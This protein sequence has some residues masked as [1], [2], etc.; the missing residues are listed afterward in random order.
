MT[1]Q[2]FDRRAGIVD[3]LGKDYYQSIT[4]SNDL[5][6]MHSQINTSRQ[7]FARFRLRNE[8]ILQQTQPPRYIGSIPLNSKFIPPKLRINIEWQSGIKVEQIVVDP[9]LSGDELMKLSVQTLL[10]ADIRVTLDRPIIIKVRGIRSYICGSEPIFNYDYI[11]KCLIDGRTPHLVLMHTPQV[12]LRS[13]SGGSPCLVDRV[14]AVN[15]PQAPAATPLSMLTDAPAFSKPF[16]LKAIGCCFF[17][18]VNTVQRTTYAQLHIALNYGGKALCPPAKTSVVGCSLRCMPNAMQMG[19]VWD[20]VLSFPVPLGQ[21][22]SG[23]RITVAL[24]TQY[25]DNA[26]QQTCVGWS[27]FLPIGYGE[28][29]Q[30]GGF[31][32]RLQKDGPV[33]AIGPVIDSASDGDAPLVDLELPK[34]EFDVSFSET[35]EEAKEYE[36]TTFVQR[37]IDCARLLDPEESPEGYAELEKLKSELLTQDALVPIT[38]TQKALVWKY[39]FQLI[40]HPELLPMLLLSTDWA[41]R[42]KVIETHLYTFNSK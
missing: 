14:L 8:S 34:H 36:E 37:I 17:H 31:T 20:E 23:V 27:N 18:A 4:T 28:R 35:R 2:D 9:L 41:D 29:L 5:S 11:R 10:A 42:N 1:Q 21:L 30:K 6:D 15:L 13:K 32:L 39:R 16:C 33:N 7:N 26:D 25:S 40:P 12:Y 22:P 24:Y 38:E 3:I 19:A